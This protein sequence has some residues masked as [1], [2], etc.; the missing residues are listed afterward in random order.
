MAKAPYWIVEPR[1]GQWT[2]EILGGRRHKYDVNWGSGGKRICDDFSRL[3]IVMDGKG[4]VEG[5]QKCI[6]LI[7]GR[8]YL[9]SPAWRGIYGTEDFVEL[10]WLHIRLLLAPGLDALNRPDIPVELPLS[11]QDRLLFLSLIAALS[12]PKPADALR[13]VSGVSSLV[14]PFLPDSWEGFLPTAQI[15]LAIKT[16]LIHMHEH[17]SEPLSLSHL[18]KV[19]QCHPTYLSNRFAALMGVPPMRHLQHLR[20]ERARSQILGSETPIAEIAQACGFPDPMHFSKAFHR[21]YGLPPSRLRGM[22]RNMDV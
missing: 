15:P 18:A 9:F 20:L 5:D 17:C 6:Q 3:Y 8:I 7:P 4:T 21:R 14:A 13:L 19:A 10:C 2:V 16:V 22:S 1:H 11:E 12:T